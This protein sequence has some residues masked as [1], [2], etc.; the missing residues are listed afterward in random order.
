[1]IRIVFEGG[2]GNQLFEIVMG[3]YLQLHFKD[4]I[5]YYI[6]KYRNEVGEYRNFELDA[7][8]IP[9]DWHRIELQGSRI[10]RMGLKYLYAGV[11]TK[12]YFMLMNICRM[13]SYNSSLDT[14]YQ[15]CLNV[16]GIY[17]IHN[18][19]S[20]KR[21]DNSWTKN[22]LFLGQW[23]WPSMCEE[24]KDEIHQFVQFKQR[25]TIANQ[26]ILDQIQSTNSVGVHIRRGDY[27][28][29]G[30]VVCSLNY[31]EHCIDVMA[32]RMDNPVFFIFSDD[33]PWVKENIKT[34]KT[35]VFVD[36]HN[37]APQ[38]MQLLSSCKHFI[39]SNSTFS[40]WSAFL[41]KNPNKI[42]LAPKYWKAGD[43]KYHSVMILDSM[44]LID[45]RE[46]L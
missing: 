35:L 34:D 24:Y 13:K 27:V 2:L 36:N 16:F 22:K 14:I 4:E 19:K 32:N 40:W 15:R 11:L 45:N 43:D 33:I 6:S 25:P 7:F 46:Y 44:E 39:M 30:L 5:Q 42:V 26:H 1:M 37:S 12:L 23:I 21:P 9:A 17:W 31:Y 18:P 38:D 8:V 29:L 3:R 10:Q 41:C 28:T 20:Y